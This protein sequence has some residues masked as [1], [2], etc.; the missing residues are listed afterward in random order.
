MAEQ[1][2]AVGAAEV[3]WKTRGTENPTLILAEERERNQ[4]KGEAA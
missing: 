2:K 1:P 3:D 4:R